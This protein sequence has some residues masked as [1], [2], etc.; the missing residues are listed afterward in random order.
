LRNRSEVA[1]F[2]LPKKSIA[3]LY[4]RLVRP[5]LPVTGH[6]VYSTVATGRTRRLFDNLV[7]Q[8]WVPYQDNDT[9]DYE[10]ALLEAIRVAVKP[11]D[12]VVIV[13]TGSG[14]S[15][16][17]AARA[18][19][20]A[21]RVTCYEGSYD[22]A[23][24]AQRTLEVNNLDKQVK[25]ICA[26]VEAG[27]S[28]YGRRAAVQQIDATEIPPCDVLVLDCEGSEKDILRKMTI[29]PRAIIVETHGMHGAP[30]SAISER[31]VTMDYRILSTS[32]AEPRQ[33]EFC[34]ANDIRIIHAEEARK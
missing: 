15:A 13:G 16:V 17:V 28:V 12:S 23:R 6:V 1:S 26:V 29:R 20:T 27:I 32:I 11:G 7:P 31:L 34:I 19:D 30:T 25:I 33:A 21:G 14:V 2:S 5:L 24:L 4:R 18:T 8:T 10:F 3:Y 9:P 22:Y